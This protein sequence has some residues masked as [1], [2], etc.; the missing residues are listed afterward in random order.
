MRLFIVSVFLFA[1]LQD[2]TPAPTKTS[3]PKQAQSA[4]SQ[5][6]ANSDQRG[7]EQSPFVV[8]TLEPTKSQREAEQEAKDRQQK[9]TN[10]RWVVI[11][12]GVLALIA[13]GQLGVYLYQ[14]I[15][16]R[17]TVKA[18]GEQSQA[19][20]RH[21][22]EAARSATAMET[23][24]SK[25][26]TGNKAVMRAYLTVNIGGGAYQ[27]RDR[28]GQTD[29]KFAVSPTV[30]NTGNTQARKVRIRKKAAILPSPLPDNFAY[31]EIGPDQEASF[32]TVAAHQSYTI[33]AILEDFVP[34]AEVSLI[35]QGNGKN[36]H[37][38]GIIIYEDIFGDTHTTK[39]G[40]WI[41]FAS[42]NNQILGWYTPGQNDAD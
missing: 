37:V 12:T 11:L 29:I 36:L 32:A 20:E 15:K 30:A 21:I 6:P 18:A 40:Q 19:M 25:I 27:E 17:Q 9:T 8:K 33:T 4:G 1:C 24:A 16:L 42:P 23:I 35:K 5:Q 31:E 2:P 28:P 14:A 7:T 26:E 41:V 38:W 22:G 13:L 10:D 3:K 34:A 39:F